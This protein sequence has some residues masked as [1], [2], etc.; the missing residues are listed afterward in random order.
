MNHDTYPQDYIS[1]I[2]NSVKTIAMVGASANDVRPSFFVLKYL[3]AKGFTV[4]PVNPGQA[5]KEIL[6]QHVYARLSDISHPIDM[7]DIFRAPDAVPAIVDEALRLDP[8]PKVIWM[9]L[10][11]RND[12]AAARAEAA[13][14]QVVMNRCPKI[15]YGKLSGEIGWNGVNSGV[16][17]SKKPVMR[18]GFQSFGIRSK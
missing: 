7:I 10:G 8:L 12:E 11:V 4:Y 1:G 16:L 3:I 17:S 15:E 18:G 6:G 13:G 9:Q 14:L 5:G 2:L